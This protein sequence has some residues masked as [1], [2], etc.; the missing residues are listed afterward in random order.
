MTR[1]LL[2]PL[3][4]VD[5]IADLARDAER[6]GHRMV[7]TLIA[8]HLSG[9]NRFDA[10]G[11]RLYAV[12][13]G[14]HMIGVCGLNV[15]PYVSDAR[16]GRVRRLYVSTAHRRRGVA[17]MLVERIVADATGTFER[18]RVRTN[19]PNAHAF[20]R[21]IGFS[22][23]DGDPECTHERVLFAPVRVLRGGHRRPDEFFGPLPGFRDGDVVAYELELPEHFELWP[24]RSRVE[25]IFVLLDVGVSFSRP[26][27]V[28]DG[29]GSREADGEDA[30]YVDLISV[31]RDG[32][33]YVFRDL[34][35]DV[36][37]PM[38]GR[39]Q[40]ILDLDELADAIDDRSIPLDLAIDGLRRWQRFLDQH[41]H[42]EDHPTHGWTDFPPKAI[43]R[44]AVIPGP[45]GDP[46]GYEG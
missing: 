12:T 43:E 36:K 6:E 15:D 9:R 41:L 28:R 20:Y 18:L 10:P 38:D 19:D 37:V 7:S 17:R 3:S 21:A 22:E 27:W 30:W 11:E 25:R 32:D 2:E 40:R 42:A 31:E 39:H 33:L 44:L 35:A 8:D 26:P 16:V 24:G 23:V 34:Y 1:P 45:L 13:L 4:D 46:V 5:R 14:G 29:V